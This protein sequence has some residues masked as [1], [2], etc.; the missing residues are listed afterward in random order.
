MSRLPA[1]MAEEHDGPVTQSMPAPEPPFMVPPQIEQE[2]AE[3]L[4]VS[5]HP[6]AD[7]LVQGELPPRH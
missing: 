6:G 5:P 7:G 2:L 1:E 4:D 3:A